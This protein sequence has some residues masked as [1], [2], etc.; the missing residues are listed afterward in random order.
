MKSLWKWVCNIAHGGWKLRLILALFYYSLAMFGQQV[1]VTETLLDSQ[2]NNAVGFLYIQNPTFLSP[3]GTAGAI[4]GATN[5][6]PI[7]IT[8]TAHGFVDGQTVYVTGVGGNTAANG[9]WVVNQLTADTYELNGSVGNGTY[10]SGG[11]G[12][13]VILVTAGRQR[14]PTAE[15][16][17]FTGT[18]TVSLY[19]TTNALAVPSG[20]PAGFT[21]LVEYHMLVGTSRVVTNQRWNVPTTGPVTIQ[22][23]V[24]Q[25][26]VTP[27]AFVTTLPQNLGTPAAGT[28]NVAPRLDHVH[29]FGSLVNNQTGTSYTVLDSDRG[30]TLTFSN[31]SAIA[32]TLPQAGASSSF[33]SG[34]AAWFSNRG[35]GTVTITPATSTI[36]GAASLA[37]TTGAGAFVVSDGTNYFAVLGGSQG[38]GDPGANCIVV[39]TALNTTTARTLTGTA[40]VITVTD[41]CGTGGNPTI[42][43]GANVASAAPTDDRIF[44][45]NG[46]AWQDK[47]IPDCDDTVGQHLNYDTATNALSCGTS[48]PASGGTL[49]TSTASATVAN[50]TTETSL[51]GSGVGSLTLAAGYFTAGKSL[52]FLVYG[53]LSDQITPNTLRI[54]AKFGSTAIL[55]TGAQTPTGSLSNRF[56][57]MECTIT[58]RTTGVS[59]TVMAQCGWL[60]NTSAILVAQ[61]DMV[62]TST[63]TV[64]TT[65]TLAVDVTA[66]WGGASA[67]DTITGT[68][69][70]M[71]TAGSGS[72]TAAAGNST[73]TG[74]YGSNPGTC[75]DGD[76]R[77]PSD[78]FYLLRCLSNAWI[79]W[80]P[81]FPMTQPVSGDFSWVNQGS[82]SVTTTN[83]GIFITSP[84]NA[85]PN[86]RA[87]TKAVPSAPYTVTIAFQPLITTASSSAVGLILRDG[88]GN[89]VT[90]DIRESGA[91]AS[92]KYTSPTSSAS[93]YTV[94]G[95]ILSGRGTVWLRINDDNTNRKCLVS[96]DG[97]NFW[98]VHSVSRT[99]FMTPTEIGFFVLNQNATYDVAMTL[100]S[101]KQE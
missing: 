79:P 57:G 25:G 22:A 19:P 91:L 70:L 93:A 48:Q 9:S 88:S 8:Q 87:R 100:L 3:V 53:Y 73:T 75:T 7:V 62:N 96:F 60:Y 55:D 34:W 29:G 20:S 6:T 4:T 33:V 41:G 5:A 35:S 27:S 90:C 39:R 99:D 47:A 59:G 21:Y 38:L 98:Q 14:Y 71:Y 66:Q 37:L 56:W 74:T 84:A 11:T 36:N 80:G 44:I 85:G 51:I 10:T 26:T 82:A 58:N 18:V 42:N 94:N 97:V 72:G 50:T 15:G 40:S 69:F 86:I 92:V 101:W 68:N 28:A 49:F 2:G 30:K 63:V 17:D 43:V 32:V 65:G 23:V 67:S 16:T 31:G 52:R 46:S 95:S 1:T 76:V 54:R 81:L 83:G 24:V 13:R 12:Q 45:G 77:F 64:D 78:S 61:F 89:L